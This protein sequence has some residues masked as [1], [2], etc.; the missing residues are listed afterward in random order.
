MP[1]QDATTK[2]QPSIT[3]LV[4]NIE[5]LISSELRLLK[6]EVR[7]K[8]GVVLNGVGA[9]TLA[10]LLALPAVFLVLLAA[11]TALMAQ[12]ISAPVAQ[13]AVG[14][15]AL[16]VAVGLFLYARRCLAPETLTLKRSLDQFRS[17][18]EMIREMFK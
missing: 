15:T 7:E 18:R 10:V 8:S 12:G 3:H 17:D 2:H 6:A 11:A 4:R 14:G 16:A 13:L 9:M 5:G 1:N